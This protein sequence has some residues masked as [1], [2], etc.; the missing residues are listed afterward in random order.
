M[1]TLASYDELPYDSLPLP[2]TQPDFLAAVA[3]LHGFEAPDPGRARILELGCAQGG[4]LIPLAWRWP[5]CECV[6]VELSRLQAQA[7]ADFVA[8]LGLSNVRILHGDLAA[9]PAD[10]GEF[11]YIIAHGVFSWIPPAIQRALLD[12]CRRHLSANGLA[13]VSFNVAAGW[14]KLLPLREALIARTDPDADAPVRL[15]QA[16]SA[17]DALEAE[18]DDPALLKEIAYLKTA[19]PSYLFHEYL[20]DCNAPMTFADFAARLD[21][22]GLRY[23][24]EAGPRRAV[25]ELEDAWG[26]APESMAG[27]W[28]DAEAALD[29]A[30]A[31]R[32]RRAL[33]A[34]DDAPCAQPPLPE[35]LEGLMFHADLASDEEVDLDSDTAQRFVNPA[36]SGH[37]IAEP[38]MKAAAMALS[39]AHPAALDYAELLDA[40]REIL[41]A[42]SADPAVD[43]DA[44]R[45]A[46]FRLVVMHGVMPTVWRGPVPRPPGERPQANA[47]ARAQAAGPGWIVSGAR[48]VAIDLDAHGRAL[49]SLLDGTRTPGELT[50]LMQARLA[51]AG[52][53][54]PPARVE[55][56]TQR[57]LWLFARQ[58]LLE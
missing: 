5:G 1:E 28:L 52:F 49:L 48:H 54:L 14:R 38:A 11:D 31:T 46:L 42:Y 37:E 20:A 29:D 27:R 17:L 4:N 8:R 53:A 47:L 25:V 10:L 57:Q 9:L 33:I 56:L 43:A 44:F 24:G 51:A 26:L 2:E 35:A 15:R 55:T 40:A 50:A 12:V 58:G 30:L 36:G 18:W 39:S 22:H 7:G 6:G 45:D 3:A 13:Y 19:L 32:F 16:R 41:Q 34:R 21:A 23:V